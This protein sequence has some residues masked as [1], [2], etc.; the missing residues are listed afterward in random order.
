M[1]AAW[2]PGCGGFVEARAVD[3]LENQPVFILIEHL[4][5]T[6][7]RDTCP[8]SGERVR[9]AWRV[10][11]EVISYVTRMGQPHS[12]VCR[13]LLA[14]SEIACI[15]CTTPHY[16]HFKLGVCS[17]R[18]DLPAHRASRWRQSP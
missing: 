12:F 5:R 9:D 7:A 13:H 16:D 1:I 14:P 3:V 6:S 18:D 15:C 17:S 11:T 10:C 2:C 8:G 4:D